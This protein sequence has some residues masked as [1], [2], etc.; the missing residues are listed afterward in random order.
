MDNIRY[1]QVFDNDE[2]L[3]ILLQLKEEF[4]NLHIGIKICVDDDK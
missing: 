3:D 2:Q 4:E 1:Q